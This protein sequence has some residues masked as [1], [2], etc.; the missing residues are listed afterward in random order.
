MPKSRKIK[1]TNIRITID[2]KRKSKKKKSDDF[3]IMG[4]INQNAGFDFTGGANVAN[5]PMGLNLK[6]MGIEDTM[7]DIT[8]FEDDFPSM[9]KRSK[10]SGYS[11]PT[12]AGRTTRATT[13]GARQKED[14]M[15][16]EFRKNILRSGRNV[17]KIIV[18]KAKKFLKDKLG[19]KNDG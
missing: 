11:T 1:G 9:S 16:K 13:R 10:Y 19:K 17:K 5:E 18:P 4:M 14:V 2:D 7:H 8:A 15:A 3:S 6:N 12:P